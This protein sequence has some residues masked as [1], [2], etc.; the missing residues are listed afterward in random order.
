M[1]LPVLTAHAQAPNAVPPPAPDL[2]QRVTQLTD[3]VDELKK[4]VHQLQEQLVKANLLPAS[5]DSPRV[6][7]GAAPPVPPVALAPPVPPAA[8]PGEAA[9]SWLHGVT[10]NAL[11]DGYYEYNFNS[12]VGRVNE[13][14]AY[15]VSSN[16]F[17]L[18]QADLVVESA[19]DLAA[20]RRFGMR[21]DFQFGQATSTLQGNPANELRPEVYRNIFQAYGTYIFPFAGGLTVDFGKWAS[22][23]GIEGNYTKDQLNYSRSLWFDYLPFYH[24]GLRSKLQINDQVAVNLWVVNGTDQTE[25]FN[26]YKDQLLGLVL[27]PTSAISLT[28]NYYQGQEHPDVIYLQSQPPGSPSLP[29]SQGTYILPIANPPDGKLQIA[30]TYITWQASKALM[31]AAEADY[32]QERLYSYSSPQRVD[33]WAVYGGYQISPKIAF[34]ARAEY[35]A[36]IGGLFSGTTQYLKEGTLTLDYRPADGFLMRGEYRRDQSN[37]PYF[38]GPVVGLLETSQPTLGFGLV[39]WFGQK[40]GPW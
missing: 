4:L 38:L 33:G 31:L 7:V 19:P 39:W 36:D 30:D 35:L 17:S 20:D 13:L 16:S 24:M 23:L 34:A 25:A 26:N 12:P 32:V 5:P 21:L 28:L 37:R 15:D 27:T 10:I 9:A 40:E 1:A 11:L 22:S 6:V 8:A 18:N 3:E 14:R 2:E 29:N